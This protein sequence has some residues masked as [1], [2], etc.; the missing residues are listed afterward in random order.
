M[1]MSKSLDEID[2]KAHW[3][4]TWKKVHFSSPQD[5]LKNITVYPN[6]PKVFYN[7]SVG[8]CVLFS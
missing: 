6:I 4:E 3:N 2:K 1:I 5:A 7:T 8:G